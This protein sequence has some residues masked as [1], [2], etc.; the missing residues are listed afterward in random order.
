MW[1]HVTDYPGGEESESGDM[2]CSATPL[3]GLSKFKD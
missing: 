3:D 1:F 2:K